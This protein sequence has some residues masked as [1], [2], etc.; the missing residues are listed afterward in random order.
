MKTFNY[1]LIATFFS[2]LLFNCKKSSTSSS[3]N[4]VTPVKVHLADAPALS[5][6]GEVNIE[7]TG[8]EFKLEDG[9]TIDLN[10]HPGII[11]LLNLA[12][13]KDTLLAVDTIESGKLSQIRLILGTNNTVKVNGLTLPMTTPS[14]QQS[15]LKL[16]VNKT[17][18][19]GVLYDLILDFDVARSIVV[20]GNNTIILKPV[21][22]VI[23]NAI[24]GSISGTIT[25]QA[26]L[27]A[28]VEAIK[29]ADT[30]ST[31]A[32]AQGNFLIRGVP[33]GQYSVVIAPQPAY[34]SKTITGVNV[35]IGNQTKLGNISF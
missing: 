28:L 24:S 32:N 26:A 31:V 7:V 25:T 6:Y 33:A 2:I 29:G 8:V 12:N 16:S 3:T 21:I 17:L 34:Q 27:P 35:T 11:N 20:T 23:D 4:G 1:I 22:R 18:E 19:P 30:L 9:K 15:G 5:Y 10:V 13:G 14:A